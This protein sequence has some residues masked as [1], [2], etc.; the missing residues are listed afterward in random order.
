MVEEKAL[1]VDV[2]ESTARGM[3]RGQGRE[4]NNRLTRALTGGRAR[5][6]KRKLEEA[7]SQERWPNWQDFWNS[8]AGGR[9]LKALSLGLG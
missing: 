5:K 7:K 9:E 6:R 8:E 1:S 3:G 2:G 4:T